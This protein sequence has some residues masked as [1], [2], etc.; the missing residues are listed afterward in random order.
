MLSCVVLRCAATAAI[1]VRVKTLLID[2]VLLAKQWSHDGFVR[3]GLKGT[4]TQTQLSQ[5]PGQ[6]QG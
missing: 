4:I 3:M 1:V 2:A 6:V 5:L